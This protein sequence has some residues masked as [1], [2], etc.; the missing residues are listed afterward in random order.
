MILLIIVVDKLRKTR[1][2][3][4]PR[5]L[6]YVQSQ[7]CD[8]FTAGKGAKTLM[9]VFIGWVSTYIRPK[10]KNKTKKKKQKKYDKKK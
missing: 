5:R 9:M 7:S 2:M 6:E 8:G 10:N 4:A 1:Q 3:S